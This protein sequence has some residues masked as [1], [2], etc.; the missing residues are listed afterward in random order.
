MRASAT[1]WNER[2]VIVEGTAGKE[3]NGRRMSDGVQEW[4]LVECS[5]RASLL[6]PNRLNCVGN[7]HNRTRTV[8]HTFPFHS[9]G[10]L[11][12]FNQSP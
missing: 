5:A 11:A 7:P 2:D 6:L 1:G 4:E 10:S 3:G 8:V 12:Q 9:F